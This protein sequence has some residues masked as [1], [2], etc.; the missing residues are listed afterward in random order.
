MIRYIENIDISFSI[1]IYRI[2][3]YQIKSDQIIYLD[4]QIQ[5]KR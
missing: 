5:K 3:S 4:K 2:V 1:S